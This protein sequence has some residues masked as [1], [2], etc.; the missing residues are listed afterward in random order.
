MVL[1]VPVR[2]LIAWIG[3]DGSEI[4]RPECR[5]PARRRG[6]HS[7]ECIDFA[8]LQ[9]YSVTP[10]ELRPCLAPTPDVKPYEVRFQG[11]NDERFLDYI[12]R[13]QCVLTGRGRGT[14]HAVACDH[15]TVYDPCGLVYDVDDADT[16]H[17]DPLTTWVIHAIR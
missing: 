16:F 2:D 15:G 14:G 13:N 8:L 5:E 10:I 17:F 3:H 12:Y 6:F 11:H 4:V 1:E 7:Q 9:G